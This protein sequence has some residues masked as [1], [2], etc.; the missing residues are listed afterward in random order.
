MYM[1][2]IKQNII[3][4]NEAKRI[5]LELVQNDG[6]SKSFKMLSELV[7]SGCMPMPWGFFCKWWSFL[8][9]GQICFLMLLYGWQLIQHRVLMYLQVYSNSAYPQHSGEQYR[10][11][12]PLVLNVAFITIHNDIEKDILKGPVSIWPIFDLKIWKNLNSSLPKYFTHS[13]KTYHPSTF[14]HSVILSFRNLSDEIFR[15]TFLRNCE[16]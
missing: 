1:Y 16:A 3:K 6:N 15:H 8:W 5:F 13:I 2:E 9:Q 7:P 12:C 14:Y 11:N 4:N 10:T